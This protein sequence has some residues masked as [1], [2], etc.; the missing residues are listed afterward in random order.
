MRS[1]STLIDVVSNTHE[2]RMC[3]NREEWPFDLVRNN[4]KYSKYYGDDTASDSYI[5]YNCHELCDIYNTKYTISITAG[6]Y[7]Y[8]LLPSRVFPK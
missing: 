7:K 3:D 8:V 5:V 6:S 1:T 4:G 2:T